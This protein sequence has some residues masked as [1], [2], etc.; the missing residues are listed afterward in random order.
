MND[1]DS[2]QDT[3]DH[4]ETVREYIG[5]AR[6][7]LRIRADRHDQSK[8][9]DP[10]KAIFDEYTPKLRGSTYGSDE[11]REYLDEMKVALDHHYANNRH[12][13]EHFDEGIHGMH[14]IDL[15][16]ML[17]DWKAAT[18]RHDDGD[19]RRSIKVN[20]ERFGYGDEIKRLLH[21]TA[22]WLDDL[23]R[24]HARGNAMQDEMEGVPYSCIGGPEHKD[25]PQK[26]KYVK[27]C[28]W[29]VYREAYLA[30]CE[31]MYGGDDE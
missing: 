13:P 21:N 1:Y 16:E 23:V 28:D 25:D 29:P 5:K 10:E 7:E 3:L 27:G 11:Y 12:H 20:A 6:R 22:D 2:T 24:K 18:L 17:I 14:L 26:P 8:L 19:L 9:E 31:R 15:L 4:I 30:T